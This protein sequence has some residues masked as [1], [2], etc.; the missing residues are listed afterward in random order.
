[1]VIGLFVLIFEVKQNT[2]MMRAQMHSDAM[3]VRSESR[4]E[5]ANSGESARIMAKL[6]DEHGDI[7][8]RK[9]T[10]SVLTTE[11][12]MRIRFRLI[13]MRDDLANLF[14]QCQEGYLDEEFCEFRLD[15]QIRGLLPQWHAVN[16]WMIGQRPSFLKEIQKLAV[17]EGIP[18]PNDEGYWPN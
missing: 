8:I 15:N 11:E 17:E 16:V 3:A 4:F 9:E 14:Y 12:V 1:V 5:D 6:M 2:E 18:P 10:I 13:G 7:L